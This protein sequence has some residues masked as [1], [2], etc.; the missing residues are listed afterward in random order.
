MEGTRGRGPR[1]LGLSRAAFPAGAVRARSLKIGKIAEVKRGRYYRG[2][3]EKGD[4]DTPSAR[5]RIDCCFVHLKTSSTCRGNSHRSLASA[6][7]DW[8][9]GR[10]TLHGKA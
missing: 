10:E 5:R 3:Q 1:R 2:P 7:V 6:G 9:A 8:R 4:L